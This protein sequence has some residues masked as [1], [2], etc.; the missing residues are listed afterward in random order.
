M[1]VA[2]TLEQLWHDVPGGTA[3]SVLG[4]AEGLVAHQRQIDLIGVAARHDAP[5]EPP[6]ES[7]IEV[8]QLRFGRRLLY[9]T[10]QHF[11]WPDVEHATGRVDV[12]HA[13]TF[14]IPG[15]VAPLVVTVHDLAFLHEPDHFT[16]NGLAFFDRGVKRTIRHADLVVCPSEAT[17]EDCRSIGLRDDRL[18]VVPWGVDPVEVT[19]SEVDRLRRRLGLDKPYVLF[20]GTIEPRKN[21]PRIIEAFER[22]ARRDC[23]LAL[24]GPAGWKEDVGSLIDASSADVRRIGFVDTDDLPALYHGAEVL[25]APS[26]REG[27]GM[28]V[29]EAMTQGTAVLTTAG[30]STAELAGDDGVLVDALDVQAIT[31]GL[32]E[33]LDT[34]DERGPRLL[35]RA[36]RFSIE[37]TAAGYAAVYAEAVSA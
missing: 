37:A 11:G 35:R 34:A 9:L 15:T 28:P 21:L 36:A 17:A 31:D 10:W 25:C 33:A 13:T 18:R 24:A 20:V 4:L 32:D 22:I 27:F 5:P 29:L 14:A 30:T 26:L 16:R 19:E 1:R 2:M 3:T 8:R 6:F 12:T 7:P 23:C